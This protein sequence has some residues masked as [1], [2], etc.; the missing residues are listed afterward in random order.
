MLVQDCENNVI[1]DGVPP[2]V[3]LET[4]LVDGAS[5]GGVVESVLFGGET[6]VL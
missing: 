1:V 4:M 3:F 5:T 2:D 6:D